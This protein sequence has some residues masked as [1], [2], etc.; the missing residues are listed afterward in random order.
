MPMTDG[1]ATTHQLHDE[2]DPLTSG[3]RVVAEAAKG[4]DV[5]GVVRKLREDAEREFD[6]DA[7]KALDA[8]TSRI[9]K[10]VLDSVKED[11]GKAG[12]SPAQ[13][14]AGVR[15]MT[16]LEL[17][18]AVS[19]AAVERLYDDPVERSVAMD[20]RKDV[21]DTEYGKLADASGAI[22]VDDFVHQ[23]TVD[24]KRALGDDFGKYAEDKSVSVLSAYD[25]IVNEAVRQLTSAQGESIAKSGL[26]P[27]EYVAGLHGCSVEDYLDDRM[28]KAVLLT[29][30]DPNDPELKA[31]TSA[32][33]ERDAMRD[34]AAYGASNNEAPSTET[35]AKAMDGEYGTRSS[36]VGPQ[37]D[38]AFLLDP[39]TILGDKAG[40][41][42][43]YVS[44]EL[45]VAAPGSKSDEK[46]GEK[47]DEKSDAKSGEKYDEKSGEK[48]DAEPDEKSGEKS[49][50]KLSR[51]V[52]WTIDD[53]G[54][55]ASLVDA[56]AD[57]AADFEKDSADQQV[58][59]NE[60]RRAVKVE[61]AQQD[62]SAQLAL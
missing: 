20:Y 1:S 21:I 48:S 59:G 12:V 49:D 57:F 58:S 2:H 17:N 26:T 61:E 13:Y 30:N 7:R 46:S 4:I 9:M 39:S 60:V 28:R 18:Y 24:A 6:D 33:V 29:G 16:V 15:G 54:M 55:D 62:R 11:A 31:A 40:A 34:I 14:A 52:A 51:F 43:R 41:Y 50:T 22:S 10:G 56:L 19:K 35:V 32:A 37:S 47:S 3:A 25:D 45:T 36:D 27:M 44:T 23:K 42:G 5:D 8:E 53:K 38:N